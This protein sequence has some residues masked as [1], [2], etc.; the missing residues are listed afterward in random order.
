MHG[1][2]ELSHPLH[3]EIKPVLVSLD[4]GNECSLDHWLEVYWLVEEEY[5]FAKDSDCDTWRETPSETH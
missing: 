3:S 1:V 5:V 2:S 4:S